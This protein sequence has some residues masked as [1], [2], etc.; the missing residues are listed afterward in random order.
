MVT[1]VII[2]LYLIIICC[3]IFLLIKCWKSKERDILLL[4][5]SVTNIGY[6]IT[7]FF[8]TR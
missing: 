5:L 4:L 7:L 2:Y 6:G 8:I 1:S 3:S